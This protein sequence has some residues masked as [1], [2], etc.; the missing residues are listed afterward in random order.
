MKAMSN[1]VR[2][3]GAAILVMLAIF[4]LSSRPSAELP[5]FGWADAAVKKGSHV[6]GY[7]LLALSY[8]KAFGWR[9]ERIAQAWGLAVLYGISDELHQAFVPGRHASALDVLLF[10]ST[11]AA[12]ALLARQRLR[13]GASRR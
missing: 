8:W 3:W 13:A 10:D 11:G 7:G 12:I 2:R 6:L 5:H 9:P 1:F 4:C